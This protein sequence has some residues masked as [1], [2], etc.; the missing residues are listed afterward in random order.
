[1]GRRVKKAVYAYGSGAWELQK[2]IL[3]VYDGWNLIHEKEVSAT[4]DPLFDKFYVWGLDLSQSIQGAGGIGGL[5]CRVAGG[6]VRHYLYDANGNVGQVVNPA[7]GAVTARYEYDPFGKAIVADGIDAA[8]NVFRYSSKFH[9]NETEL[10]YYG[11]RFYSPELGRWLNRDRIEEQGGFNLYGYCF[12]SSINLFDP[13]GL[14][15]GEDVTDPDYIMDGLLYGST[16]KI[17]YPEGKVWV[18]FSTYRINAGKV[19]QLKES[20][21][22]AFFFSKYKLV[23]KYWTVDFEMDVNLKIATLTTGRPERGQVRL[24]DTQM[25]DNCT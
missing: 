11:F 16:P 13:F 17:G 19:K 18:E 14:Y 9:D 15:S 4:G 5:V 21:A 3:F 25:R 6:E 2:E 24:R 10:V 20:K 7:D 23:D 1:L 8:E 22:L 12:N